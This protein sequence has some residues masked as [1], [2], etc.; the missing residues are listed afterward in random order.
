LLD[1]KTFDPIFDSSTHIISYMNYHSLYL[2]T[3]MFWFSIFLSAITFLYF[4][5]ITELFP[6]TANLS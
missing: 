1:K 4:V 6:S 3:L 2:I 5:V